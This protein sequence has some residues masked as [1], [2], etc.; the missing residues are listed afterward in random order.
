[1]AYSKTWLRSAV[2]LGLV[3]A[4]ML[5]FAGCRKEPKPATLAAAQEAAE[6]QLAA[7]R[8]ARETKKPKEAARA[9]QQAV[10]AE[11]AARRLYGALAA[12]TQ[13][14]KAMGGAVSIAAREA[15]FVAR[16]AAEDE[17]FQEIQGSLK[18][19]SVH[20]ASAAAVAGSL[21]GFEKAAR[22]MAEAEAQGKDPPAQ[23]KALAEE[24][25]QL[26][27]SLL[28]LHRDLGRVATGQALQRMEYH[29]KLSWKEMADSLEQLRKSPTAELHSMVAMILAIAGQ[30]GPAL[31]EIESADPAALK[32]PQTRQA[33]VLVRAVIWHVN[34]LDGKA[35]ELIQEELARNPPTRD[36]SD[37][38]AIGNAV[39]DKGLGLHLAAALCLLCEQRFLE[40]D[41]HL[42]VAAQLLPDAQLVKFLQSQSAAAQGD[43]DRAAKLA[44]GCQDD[45]NPWLKELALQRLQEVRDNPAGNRQLFADPKFLLKLSMTFCQEQAKKSEAMARLQG[46]LSTARDFANRWGNLPKDPPPAT[47][48][49]P[50]A[51]GE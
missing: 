13:A 39:A 21:L 28:K 36:D 37:L 17:K 47:T 29:E 30:P 34:G 20:K 16:L 40:A 19:R 15:V 24:G 9:A 8:T 2:V 25:R 22:L 12:P 5:C 33:Q 4:G 42:A 23:A 1:M 43:T 45:N 27:G 49:K 46:L 41:Q 50:K 7:A 3:L 32:T 26:L 6:K 44:E 48:E 31:I 18:A 51:A 10:E 38:S 14:D 11:K 35:V